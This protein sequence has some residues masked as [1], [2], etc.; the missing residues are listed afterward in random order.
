MAAPPGYLHVV[1]IIVVVIHVHQDVDI[2][3]LDRS[4]PFMAIHLYWSII[5]VML[6]IQGARYGITFRIYL[7]D[8]PVS[9]SCS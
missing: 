4:R 5:T 8:R 1:S 6:Q 3:F 7:T 2:V 9:S